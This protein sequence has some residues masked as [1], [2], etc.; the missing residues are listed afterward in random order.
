LCETNFDVVTG[1]QGQKKI[2]NGKVLEEEIQHLAE[3]LQRLQRNLR[4]KDSEVGKNSSNFDKQAYL[5]QRRLQKFRT[6][7]DEIR[8][9]EIQGMA[10]ASLSIKSSSRVNENLVSG[11]KSN[12]SIIFLSCKLVSSI[13]L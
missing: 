7:S 11:G 13:L 8:V 5:L 10:E 12:V 6:T 1:F 9:K 3:K 4:V 2:C